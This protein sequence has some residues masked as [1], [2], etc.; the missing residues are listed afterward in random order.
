M[1]LF[2]LFHNTITALVAVPHQNRILSTD[3]EIFQ[4]AKQY[5]RPIFQLHH[6]SGWTVELANWI[7][8]HVTSGYSFT[9]LSEL[10]QQLAVENEEI[11]SC[12]STSELP[13]PSTD[14][15]E[16]IF[17]ETV[18]GY[19]PFYC[20]QM[21]EIGANVI[22]LDHTFKISKNIGYKRS[23]DGKWIN[24]YGCAFIVMNEKGQVVCWQLTNSEGFSQIKTQLINLRDRL[25]DQGSVLDR[26]MV[27]NCCKL[28]NNLQDVFGPITV[29]LDLFHAIQ[30][31]T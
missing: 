14:T 4:Q 28:G 1:V 9:S 12:E 30:R 27:D 22:S 7:V 16:T 5:I 3:P 15:I 11:A 8:V 19:L 17:L 13:F 20:Q 25:A 26:V 10:L 21:R 24:Q 6:R 29:N 23:S 2:Y 31:I 18:T